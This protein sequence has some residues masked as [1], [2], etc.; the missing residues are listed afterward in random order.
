MERA[1]PR[2]ISNTQV[3]VPDLSRPWQA[4]EIISAIRSLIIN[5]SRRVV[6]DA[7]RCTRAYPNTVAPLRAAIDEFARKGLA[8]E[9][10]T[11][12]RPRA[13]LGIRVPRQAALAEDLEHEECLKTTFTFAKP[14]DVHRLVTAVVTAVSRCHECSPGVLLA[15]EW[16]LNEVADNV[17]Q[18]ARVESGTL[19]AHLDASKSYLS[20][21]VA[22]VGVGVKNSFAFSGHEFR[23]DAAAIDAAMQRGVTRDASIHM[24]NGLWGLRELV[25]KNSGS[26]G[27][28][29][30]S[31]NYLMTDERES[32][33]T[34]LPYL[35]ET[36]RGTSVDF[37]LKLD[38][39]IDVEAALRGYTPVNLR[40]EEVENTAGE[41]V[42]ALR[43][44]DMGT[45]TRIAG[46]H[47]RNFILNLLHEGARRVVIDC[48][49][50]RMSSS[51]IDEV[52]GMLVQ[53]LG[54]SKYSQQIGVKN[55][56]R[57]DAT[58]MDDV[59]ARRIA[60]SA[61]PTE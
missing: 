28:K 16:G 5:G 26:L 6:I 46:R 43:E 32:V 57:M 58:I 4:G 27:I 7:R 13:L 49:D 48:A 56:S 60:H 53:S 33:I 21:C 39:E 14:E 34:D 19:S 23:S 17:I 18:H 51:F 12:P 40:L 38:Q 22:D 55:L 41:H 52:F 35:D 15:L 24:G 54:F 45:G 44:S 47:A 30:G 31:A 20:I 25:R 36:R 42:V 11:G 8:V 2:I 9:V 61:R 1:K 29:S 59:V 50:V 3:V 10:D 37:Q